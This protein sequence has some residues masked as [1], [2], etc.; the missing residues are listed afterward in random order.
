MAKKRRDKEHD[1]FSL[2]KI[3]K[4]G[5]AALTIGVGAAAF[6]NSALSKKIATDF[7]PSVNKAGKVAS[8]HLRDSKAVRTGLEKRTT[9]KDI[10]EALT[11]GKKTF[12]E[13]SE[14]LK[15]NK[16]LRIDNTRKNTF[17]GAVKHFEQIKN[18]DVAY[19]FRDKRKAE[20]MAKNVYKLIGDPKYKDKDKMVIAQ[21][22][23]EAYAK[24]EENT[25]K[26]ENGKLGFTKFLS[27]RFK[28][29]NF[30]DKE[31]YEFLSNIYK[32]LQDIEADVANSQGRINKATTKLHK[33][34][35]ETLL[36][37]P[38]RQDK[39]L[40]KVSKFIKDK[41]EIDVDLE[42]LFMGSKAATLGEV[43][44]AIKA[45]K[46]EAKDFNFTMKN[47]RGKTI[48]HSF[49]DVIK[50]LEGLSDDIIFDN[51]I[52]IDKDGN[53][54]SDAEIREIARNTFKG[55]S[56]TTLGKIFGLTDVRLDT[57]KAS[58]TTFRALSTG[59]EAAYEIGNESTILTSSKVAVANPL[60]GKSKLFNLS[61]DEE[62]NLIMSDVIAEGRLRNNMHGKSARLVK[63]M[64]GTNKDFITAS[65]N[66][67]LKAL[68]LGQSGA[69]GFLSKL[70]S[71]LTAKDS[72]DFSKNI[73]K[74][75][76]Q[77]YSNEESAL[78]KIDQ[79]AR[80]Y[81]EKSGLELTE[82]NILH[83]QAE[84]GNKILKDNKEVANMLNSLTA[85][86][87]ITDESIS[88]LLHSGTITSD[89]SLRI[90]EVLNNK[91]YRNAEELL[92]L[93]SNNGNVQPFN[94]DLKNI[95]VRGLSNSDYI[96]SMQNISQVN[97]KNMFG[98]SFEST[99]VMNIEDIIRREA[100]KE[101]MLRESH[102]GVKAGI[103]NLE[104]VLQNS[105]LSLEQSK[106]LRYLANW[107]IM[108]KN[109]DIYND[110]D[111]VI[112]LN[113]I[114]TKVR[115]FDD[116]MTVSGTF[117]EGY[118]SMIDDLGARAQIFE[119]TVGNINQTYINEYNNYTFLKESAL[120]RLTQIQDIND[121]IKIAG[122][123]GKELIAGRNDLN[124]YTTLTQ[125]PQFMV[126]RL[127]WGVE[128]LGLNLSKD[129][130]S[131]TLDY[132]K[133]IGL[134]RILPAAG[135][136]ALYDYLDF[137]SENFTGVSITGAGA[138][139]LA[140][141]DKASRRLAYATGVGQAIDWF[142]ETS[143]IADYWTGSTDFQTLEERED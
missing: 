3:T 52:R 72:D 34:L 141:V 23:Q 53:L 124:N 112:H 127:S 86:N 142:K 121:A 24:L 109:L 27:E 42:Q 70:K 18:S 92:N 138:N 135:A 107:S 100:I 39:L 10:K 47:D 29:N 131:S 21:L 110:V 117:R 99:N 28:A 88:S 49:N 13:T 64:V 8:K 67:I 48:T 57:E 129:S 83:A 55:F 46:F 45:G 143:V 113:D 60:T 76:K 78:D 37:S 130:T 73:L 4:V 22:A 77:F 85:M 101:V 61:L 33:V 81:L 87:Q 103:S 126:A 95:L 59:K 54:F 65:D 118:T 25:L 139:A 79:A 30:S 80:T 56:D 31:E 51:S 71:R 68:D 115:T 19:Q 90:L 98:Y 6:N 74:R 116:L 1:S 93:I 94:Q 105:N 50:R 15:A 104:N 41:T 82:E 2:S 11:L 125:I 119:N 96:S 44:E 32:S 63:E 40:N 75:Q 20:L 128:S 140:N 97:S 43:K 133:N 111:A 132:I 26:G 12:K 102:G 16:K 58:F 134:K 123:A 89:E 38:Q 137:E 35:D 108:Q 66:E 36:E 5:A 106:N 9:G 7:I 62:D 136:L 91:D 84:I 114:Y 69:P 122:E 120:S 17:H 14:A